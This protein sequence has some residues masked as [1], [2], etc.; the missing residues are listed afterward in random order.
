MSGKTSG[1]ILEL[2]KENRYIT[3]PELSQEI[4][5]AERTIERNLQNLQNKNLL[6]R[7][8]GAKGGYWEVV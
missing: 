8:G 5:V 6:K 2:I 4:G 7:V 3:I 1:K